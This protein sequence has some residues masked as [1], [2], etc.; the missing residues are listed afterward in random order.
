MKAW[1]ETWTLSEEGIEL[2][3]DNGWPG[4]TVRGPWTTSGQRE[5]A[6]AAPDMARV[7]LAIEWGA[8][9]FL[10]IDFSVAGCPSCEGVEKP[11]AYPVEHHVGHYPNC[12][13]NAALRKAGIR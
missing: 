13:L 2:P 7:L 1:E 11:T 8:E 10:A 3:D 4:P 6:S 12:A 9:V 5:L